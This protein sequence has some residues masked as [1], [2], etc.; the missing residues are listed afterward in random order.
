MHWYKHQLAGNKKDIE[1]LMQP[2]NLAEVEYGQDSATTFGMKTIMEDVPVIFSD[3]VDKISHSSCD[4]SIIH[5][6]ADPIFPIQS[7]RDLQSDYPD[8]IELFEFEDAGFTVLLSH[9]EE[10]VNLLSDIVNDVDSRF[11]EML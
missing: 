9:T 2:E 10:V 5:G 8:R 1:I 7:M 11:T 6:A 3:Y 4:I